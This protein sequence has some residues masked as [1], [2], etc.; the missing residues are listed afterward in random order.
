MSTKLKPQIPIVIPHEYDHLFEI[1]WDKVSLSQYASSKGYQKG[2]GNVTNEDI[3][4]QWEQNFYEAFPEFKDINSDL[5]A[6]LRLALPM[7]QTA[8]NPNM[9]LIR[10]TKEPCG[11]YHF[12]SSLRWTLVIGQN[13]IPIHTSTD[14]KFLHFFNEWDYHFCKEA[15]LR[16]LLEKNPQ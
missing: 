16:R 8:S 6:K 3:W 14:A 13:G 10:G 11:F 12:I 2:H 4:D 15:V 5:K 1:D 7:T 9:F